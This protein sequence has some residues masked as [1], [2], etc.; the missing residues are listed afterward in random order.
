MID[1]SKYDMNDKNIRD[2][3]MHCFDLMY[4]VEYYKKR[5]RRLSDRLSTLEDLE[6]GIKALKDLL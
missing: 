2:L 3:V 1:F 4:D 6:K 5:S